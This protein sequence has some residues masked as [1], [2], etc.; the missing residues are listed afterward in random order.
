VRALALLQSER[1]AK[2]ERPRTTAS[3]AVTPAFCTQCGAER[4][5]Q[6]RFC[7]QCGTAFA[8][9]NPASREASA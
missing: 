3:E 7:A 9:V 1:E 8:A 6:D 5:L 2:R 4:R